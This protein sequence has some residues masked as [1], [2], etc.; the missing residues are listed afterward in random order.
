MGFVDDM[1]D[2]I[3]AIHVNDSDSDGIG[4]S[5]VFLNKGPLIL[6]AVSKGME[7]VTQLVVQLTYMYHQVWLEVLFLYFL[8]FW[9]SLNREKTIVKVY[10]VLKTIQAQAFGKGLHSSQGQPGSGPSSKW[11][12]DSAN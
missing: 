7:T 10:L 2:H 4:P 9:I 11:G 3:R 5:I 12:S 1:D 6:V 8:H